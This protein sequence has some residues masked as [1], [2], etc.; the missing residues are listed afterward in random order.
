MGMFDTIWVPCP[1]C[2]QKQG[3]QTKSG[4]CILADYELD[5]AP[6]DAM[7]AVNTYAPF[8]CSKCGTKFE[9]DFLIRVIRA[10]TKEFKEESQC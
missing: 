2:G 6:P 1:K 5:E 10:T 3:A 9:V 7:S 4:D 8:T